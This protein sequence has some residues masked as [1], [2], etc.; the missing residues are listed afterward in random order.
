MKYCKFSFLLLTLMSLNI[1]AASNEQKNEQQ[2]QSA[3]DNFISTSKDFKDWSVNCIYEKTN[4]GQDSKK[5]ILRDCQT[6][7]IFAQNN[8]QIMR[9]YTLHELENNAEKLE[10]S[11][12]P[13]IYFHVPLRAFLQPQIALQIDNNPAVVVP[14]NF[15]DEAGCYGGGKV[16]VSVTDQLRK[17]SN[18]KVLFFNNNKEAITLDL[19]LSGYTAAANYLNEQSNN[20]GKLVDIAE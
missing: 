7:H 18:A 9:V 1:F 11:K 16:D 10:L 8:Q 4:D 2:E 17:G 15:C 14:Y 12:Q 5:A 3:A 20:F 6:T 13:S 19:S